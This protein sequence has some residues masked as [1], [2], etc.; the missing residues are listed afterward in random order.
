MQLGGRPAEF[1][2][3]FANAASGCSGPDLRFVTE[4]G[5][6]RAEKAG[7]G[8]GLHPAAPGCQSIRA[9]GNG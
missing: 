6:G 3:A 7:A 5:E 8:L 1:V 2:T 4:H 9:A